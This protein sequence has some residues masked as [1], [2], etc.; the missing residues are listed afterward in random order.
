MEDDAII[1]KA[2]Q[3]LES[4]LYQPEGYFSDPHSVRSYLRLQYEGALSESFRVMFLDNRNGLISC[5]EMFKGTI[6]SASVY[7]REIV[8][9][10]IEFNAAAV[11]LAHNHPS[12]HSE[13]SQAD[14]HLTKRLSE[15]LDLIDVRVLDHIVV[16]S[17]ECVSFAERG[18]I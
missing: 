16:G 15:A 17:S 9:A 3:I 11:I 1:G 6:N 8:R 2:L 18:L 7:P 13:P 14:I 5:Q 4:R 10:S 12:G